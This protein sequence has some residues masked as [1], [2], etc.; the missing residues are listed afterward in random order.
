MSEGTFSDVATEVSRIPA[1]VVHGSFVILVIVSL[2]YRLH[3]DRS[4][5]LPFLAFA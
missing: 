1:P 4:Q 2:K 5:R 3:A